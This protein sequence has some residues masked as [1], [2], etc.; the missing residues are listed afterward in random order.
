MTER[1]IRIV[2][3]NKGRHKIRPLATIIVTEDKAWPDVKGL[4]AQTVTRRWKLAEPP[5]KRELVDGEWIQPPSSEKT[6]ASEAVDPVWLFNCPSCWRTP[7]ISAERWHGLW[8]A[9]ADAGI[10]QVDISRA[11]I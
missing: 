1:R 8:V 7:E 3:T 11:G 9:T 10:A 5:P 4:H 6:R 2:C